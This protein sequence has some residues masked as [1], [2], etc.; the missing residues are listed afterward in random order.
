MRVF[1]DVPTGD[2]SPGLLQLRA[3]VKVQAVFRGRLARRACDTL[4]AVRDKQAW[5]KSA[6][7]KPEYFS[8]RSV[9]CPDAHETDRPD[10][11]SAKEGFSTEPASAKE[12][13]DKQEYFSAQ[14]LETSDVQEPE[15]ASAILHRGKSEEATDGEASRLNA[16]GVRV[17]FDVPTGDLSPGLLQFRAAVKVQAVFRGRLARKRLDA[18]KALQEA[19]LQAV[20]LLQARFRSQLHRRRVVEGRAAS[21]I[22]RRFRARKVGMALAS[23][24]AMR[25]K[26]HNY[27]MSQSTSRRL[28]DQGFLDTGQEVII[29]PEEE[30][31]RKIQAF[32]RGKRRV[33]A[34]AV[35]RSLVAKGFAVVGEANAEISKLFRR[36]SQEMVTAAAHSLAEAAVASDRAAQRA[37]VAVAESLLQLV[38]GGEE[39][40]EP[41]KQ[42]ESTQ[43]EVGVEDVVESIDKACAARCH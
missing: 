7:E 38:V 12:A 4:R 36:A 41:E 33:E 18:Q 43:R 15:V 39:P 8:A 17:F 5:A 20:L 40:E 22:Q 14:S 16:E 2:L 11:A 30:A 19:R 10:A 25:V 1:F 26:V 37:S 27:H 34:V 21:K 9:E 31:A 23:M 32:V 24:R 13:A 29:N 3:A 6:A 35:R 42:S 28:Q